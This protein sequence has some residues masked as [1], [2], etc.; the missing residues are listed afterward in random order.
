[1]WQRVTALVVASLFMDA[2]GVPAEICAPQSL[3]RDFRL[4]WQVTHGAKGP[5]VEGYVYNTTL[6]NAEG[7]RLQI[8]RLDGDG[9]SSALR[10][11]GYTVSSL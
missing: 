1:V 10:Q 8:E 4:E 2:A 5:P 3:E 11:C 7:M 6:R 9:K